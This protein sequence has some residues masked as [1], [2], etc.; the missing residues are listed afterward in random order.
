MAETNDTILSAGDE[1]FLNLIRTNRKRR[2]EDDTTKSINKDSGNISTYRLD[3]GQDSGD[4]REDRPDKGEE[5]DSTTRK[6]RKRVQEKINAKENNNEEKSND[7][8][9]VGSKENYS[10][11]EIT[12]NTLEENPLETTRS[13][14][15]EN[16]RNIRNALK[17]RRNRVSELETELNAK[18][19][20]L[21]K[22]DSVSEL[23]TQ[24]KE[25][26]DKLATLKKYED[27]IGLYGTEG[28]KEEYYDKVD[29]IKAGVLDI[30][31]DYNV[32]EEVI[33]E[34]ITITNQRQL[35]E[36][37]GQYFDVYSVQDIRKSIKEIQ[38]IISKREEAEE[39]PVKTR[40]YLLTTFAK[41]KD[42]LE[43]QSRENIKLASMSAWTELSETY[44]NPASG[45]SI[46][47]EKSGDKEHNETRLGILNNSS[48]E[49]GKLVAILC[50]NGLTSLPSNV[51]RALASR[52]QLGETAAYAIVQA[53][54]L[55][56]EN[57]ELRSELKKFTNYNRP[58]S[59]AGSSSTFTGK[60]LDGKDLKGKDLTRFIFNKAQGLQ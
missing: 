29:N 51:A 17:A 21:K 3:S 10:D 27:I 12:D 53:E 55:K 60:A 41:K 22:L 31:K 57:D 45:V 44:S 52:F 14:K 39:N 38:D 18:N 46:L 6:I 35:N 34:A 47:Q 36:Y 7:N 50:D 8:E 5:Q 9:E 26:Q 16:F 32:P 23:E 48:K 56:K 30:A 19:E 11:E 59:S 40:E 28:F 24:L 49:Y 58:L 13:T 37:L 42:A 2:Y 25:A 43:K 20:E 1:E 54:Q 15:E 33:D 4:R